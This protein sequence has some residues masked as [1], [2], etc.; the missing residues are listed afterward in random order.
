MVFCSA[1][2]RPSALDSPLIFGKELFTTTAPT[3]EQ[4][5]FLYLSFGLLEATIGAWAFV[6]FLKTLGQV[7]G[8]S[9]WRALGSTLLAIPMFFVPI[10]VVFFV[11]KLVHG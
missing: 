5:P 11:F 10:F 8:F 1:H 7:H 6:V 3:I 9:A 2:L 4:R